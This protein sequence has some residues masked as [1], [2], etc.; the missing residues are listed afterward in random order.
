MFGRKYQRKTT[1]Q[2]V[3]RVTL[4]TDFTSS[5]SPF[6]EKIRPKP[7]IKFNLSNLNPNALLLALNPFPTSACIPTTK[8]KQGIP[9]NAAAV[10]NS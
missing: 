9:K 8:M 10:N 6:T 3:K 2:L 1:T 5:T 7:L 4:A